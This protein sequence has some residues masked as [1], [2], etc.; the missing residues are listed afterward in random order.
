[1]FIASDRM[2][3]IIEGVLI[4]STINVSLYEIEKIDLNQIIRNV[5]NG[6]EVLILKK[7]ANITFERLPQIQVH[8]P[9][10]II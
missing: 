9:T 10:F 7:D 3:A 2:L 5:G 6:L 4:Y 8:Q 1:M